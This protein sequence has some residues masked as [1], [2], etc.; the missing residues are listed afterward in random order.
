VLHY[1]MI[2]LGSA[3]ISEEGNARWQATLFCPRR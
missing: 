2:A 3:G 1:T